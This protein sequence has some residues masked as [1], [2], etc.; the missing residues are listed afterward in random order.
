VTSCLLIFLKSTKTIRA[1]GY[2]ESGSPWNERT[3]IEINYAQF[4]GSAPEADIGSCYRWSA[5]SKK[6]ASFGAC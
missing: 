1:L 3:F 5:E 4:S 6:F 2:A